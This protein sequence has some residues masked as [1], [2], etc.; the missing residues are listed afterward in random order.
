VNDGALHQLAT[1]LEEGRVDLEQT[2]QRA[3]ALRPEDGER[4]ELSALI[5]DAIGAYSDRRSRRAW[6]TASVVAAVAGSRIDRPSGIWPRRFATREGYLD[7]RARAIALL[8]FIEADD[9]DEESAAGLHRESEAILDRL[10]DSTQARFVIGA[11]AAERAL[12]FRR[13][14]EA[15]AILK[16]ILSL[17]SLGDRERGAAQALLATALGAAGRVEEAERAFQQTS[18][19]FKRAGLPSGALAADLER[20]VHM[21]QTGDVAAA[22][23]V[24]AEVASLA[25]AAQNHEVEVRARLHLGGLI[26]DSGQRREGAGQFELAASAARR[27]G[28]NATVIVAL[29]NAADELR[30]A[31]DLAGA[32]RV[33]AEALAV[34]ATRATTVDLAKAKYY[35]AT[36]RYQQGNR[37]EAYRLL[38]EAATDFRRK[39]VEIG[40]DGAPQAREHLQAELRKLAGLREQMSR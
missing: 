35:L 23:S 15:I 30:H 29:C 39:L 33:L 17:P 20:G 4:E 18:E 31:H 8:A 40:A 34:P 6:A 10:K 27:A 7:I 9:G 16:G 38:D 14:D 1:D 13:A 19:S 24:L 21:A 37:Q 5:G 36:L 2:K 25:A 32:E 3:S 26:G 11:T 22:R 12:R 28:D